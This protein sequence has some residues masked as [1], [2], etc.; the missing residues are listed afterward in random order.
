MDVSIFL[1]K[2]LGIYLVII[3]IAMFIN[4]SR[5]KTMVDDI[6]DNPALLFLTGILAL[7]VGILL[8]ISHN[9][10]Q[11]DWR[12]VITV[13]AWLSLIK[14]VVRVLFP[15][16]ATE[17]SAKFI[18]NNSAYYISAFI[19]LLLGIFLSYFGFAY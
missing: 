1:A 5:F 3:G 7:I 14:G 13:I 6:A 12:V 10:W 18:Q 16:T 8:V 17:W 11:M 19:T 2:A 4:A 15:L 9:I